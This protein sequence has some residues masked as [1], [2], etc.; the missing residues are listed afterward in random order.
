VA[1]N[2]LDPP[3][4]TPPPR[5]VQGWRPPDSAGQRPE[6]GTAGQRKSPAVVAGLCSSGRNVTRPDL[7]SSVTDGRP[8]RRTIGGAGRGLPSRPRFYRNM[9]NEA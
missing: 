1:A 5:K 9:V 6:P 8:P 2:R 4:F 7:A 3:G